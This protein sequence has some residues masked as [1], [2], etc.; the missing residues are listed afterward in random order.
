MVVMRY[1]DTT[2]LAFYGLARPIV[3]TAVAANNGTRFSVAACVRYSK[4]YDKDQLFMV[5][6][7]LRQHLACVVLFLAACHDVQ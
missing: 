6:T 3:V 7:V 4:L 1:L 2:K 5:I